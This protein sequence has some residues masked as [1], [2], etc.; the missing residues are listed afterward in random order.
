MT[1]P[2]ILRLVGLLVASTSMAACSINAAT[3]YEGTRFA[4]VTEYNATSGQPVNLSLG[5]KRRIVA[6]VP[7]QDPAPPPT[8]SKPSPTHKG[9]A[10]SLV[11]MFDVGPGGP[12]VGD[13]ISIRS[14]FAS[15]M[16]ARDWTETADAAANI[17]N[18]FA[19]ETLPLLPP[20]ADARRDALIK[21]LAARP[22][23]NA[24]AARI[25]QAAGL[26]AAPP[27]GCPPEREALCTLQRA[28]SRTDE[29]TLQRLESASTQVIFAPAR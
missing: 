27:P 8:E 26:R 9:E 16:A 1:T 5:Y 14:T 23:N 25:L 18:L 21:A 10:L 13:G 19:R 20:A 2:L 22:I 3:F 15:G 24:E 29:T 28:L 6:I 7:P 4:F 12:N 11:S 17:K